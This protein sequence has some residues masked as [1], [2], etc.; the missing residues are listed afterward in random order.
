MLLACVQ[1]WS[2]SSPISRRTLIL[3]ASAKVGSSERPPPDGDRVENEIYFYADVEPESILR[4]ETRLQECT[5]GGAERIDL[6]IH[7]SGGSAT[8]GLFASDLIRQSNVPIHTFVDGM[9]ASSAS[10]MAVSGSKRFMSR[11]SL[12]LMHQPSFEMGHAKFQLLKDEAYNLQLITDHI[13]DVYS[14][15]TT[16]PKSLVETCLFNERYLTARECLRYSL[17]DHIL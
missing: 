13:V 15:C 5:R 7:S 17:V 11:H 4:L 16:M 8:L 2:F 3:A 14:T 12:V 6:R 10:L 1:P 9:A